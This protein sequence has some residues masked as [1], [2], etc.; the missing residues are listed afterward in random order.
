[1]IL[2]GELRDLETMALAMTAAETGHLVFATL[3]TRG[4][5]ASVDRLIDSFPANQQPMIRTMLSESLIAVISQALIKRA[6]GEGRV[7]AY[8]IMVTNHAISNLIREGKT[9]QIQS[10]MQTGRREGMIL[11]EQHVRELLA[12]GVAHPGEAEALLG[13]LGANANPKAKMQA[14]P[15]MPTRVQAEPKNLAPKAF[16][17]EPLDVTYYGKKPGAAPAATAAPVV[18]AKPAAR[19]AAPPPPSQASG[20][21]RPVPPPMGKPRPAAPAPAAAVA[22]RPAAPKPPAP[23][24]G[25]SPLVDKAEVTRTKPTPPPAR[26]KPAAPAMGKAGIAQ[27]ASAPEPTVLTDLT[28]P[29]DGVEENELMDV[30]ESPVEIGLEVEPGA[31]TPTGTDSDSM[32]DLDLFSLSLPDE[33]GSE[34]AP[35]EGDGS[36][37]PV[38]PPRKKAG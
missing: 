31:P 8:E 28:S 26:P 25:F 5:A 18:A 17:P 7:A 30:S 32:S 19:P 23:T 22:P 12:N 35:D 2:V 34:P 33:D 1:M 16:K 21:A 10:T 24:P 3:H 11:M 27:K 13:M 9:F 20:V 14:T 4:A 36:D 6:S 15:T 37:M 38:A 29:E